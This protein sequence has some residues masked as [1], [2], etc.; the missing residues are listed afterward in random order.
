M[1]IPGA[2]SDLGKLTSEDFSENGRDLVNMFE[3]DVREREGIVEKSKLLDLAGKE[4][5]IE[6][7]CRQVKQ[8]MQAPE[9]VPIQ[10]CWGS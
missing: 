1:D 7:Q 2:I 10:V 4:S 3:K 9:N 8:F 5:R 6:R